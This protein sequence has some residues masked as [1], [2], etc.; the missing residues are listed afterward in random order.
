MKLS[1][2]QKLLLLVAEYRDDRDLKW[3][4]RVVVAK[5]CNGFL[6]GSLSEAFDSLLWNGAFWS[7]R[8]NENAKHTRFHFSEFGEL[9]LS[10]IGEKM[11]S[12]INYREEDLSFP[13]H[14]VCRDPRWSPINGPTCC[15]SHD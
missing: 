10:A 2:K 11:L 13:R 4:E 14:C 5:D 12:E 8:F 1:E 9:R 6:L 15:G 7:K 3:W